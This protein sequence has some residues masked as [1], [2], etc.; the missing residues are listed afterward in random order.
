MLQNL[1]AIPL[2]KTSLDVDNEV[3]LDILNQIKS[4]YEKYQN[5]YETEWNCVVHSTQKNHNHINYNNILPYYGKEYETFCSQ[6]HLNL[7]YHNYCINEIWYNYYVKYSSQEIHQHIS[8]CSETNKVNIFS[9]VHFLKINQDH[10]KIIFY[11]P[12]LLSVNEEQSLK[13]KSYYNKLDIN[14]SFY[15][16]F[17]ELDVKEGD[18]IIFPSFLEH[19]VFQQKVDEPRI[20]IAFNITTEWS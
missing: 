20:T 2:W 4:N 10:P 6:H 8:V 14:H 13:V 18:F 17:F 16:R 7:N 19:A 5:Y 11:N 1:F 15:H 9:G 3:K 12:N